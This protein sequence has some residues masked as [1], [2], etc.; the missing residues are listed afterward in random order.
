MLRPFFI[1]SLRSF[2]R[3]SWVQ[4][5]HIQLHEVLIKTPVRWQVVLMPCDLLS[6]T[7]HFHLYQ[8]Q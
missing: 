8:V 6:V 4:I 5:E 1:L 7:M 2:S 3:I